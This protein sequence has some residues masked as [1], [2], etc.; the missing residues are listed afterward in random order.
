MQHGPLVHTFCY[1]AV[2][3]RVV[4]NIHGLDETA[5]YVLHNALP[6]LLDVDDQKLH[7]GAIGSI[8]AEPFGDSKVSGARGPGSLPTEDAGTEGQVLQGKRGVG[9]IPSRAGGWRQPGLEALTG[10][11]ELF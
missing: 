3:N 10:G 8:N 11:K 5:G 9:H 4:V 2:L 7:V 1:L 6:A